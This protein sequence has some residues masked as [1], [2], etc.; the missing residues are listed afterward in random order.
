MAKA[1]AQAKVPTKKQKIIGGI[2][3][4]LLGV[5]MI[6][7][8][9]V[10]QNIDKTREHERVYV[11]ATV[12]RIDYVSTGDDSDKKVAYI[13]YVIDGEVEIG[14]LDNPGRVSR[15]DTIEIY[16]YPER[17]HEIHSEAGDKKMRNT[18]ISIGSVFIVVAILMMIGKNQKTRTQKE[19]IFGREIEVNVPD[20]G[21]YEDAINFEDNDNL[22]N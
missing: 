18:F 12:E 9:I 22:T 8:S 1:K 19:V 7:G 15:G 3:I 21:K 20:N 2:F 14:R 17:P 6:A 10:K 16:Y 11:D 13:S 5:A 4:I